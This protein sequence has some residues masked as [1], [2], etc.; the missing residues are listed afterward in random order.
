MV[1][2]SPSGIIKPEL[3]GTVVTWGGSA[4]SYNFSF[5]SVLVK[6]GS[7]AI[8]G[9]HMVIVD[10]YMEGYVGPGNV[11]GI[12]TTAEGTLLTVRV[13]SAGSTDL[14]MEIGLPAGPS[15]NDH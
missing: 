5:G 13:P 4:T 6:K 7:L 8:V 10:G 2:Q 9:G 12:T 3:N 1:F 14:R 11:L 15:N